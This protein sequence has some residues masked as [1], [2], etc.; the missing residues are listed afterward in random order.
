MRRE[1]SAEELLP[2]TGHSS[3][4]MVDYYNRK[5]LDMALEGLPK[6]GAAAAD[7]LFK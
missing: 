7:T 2:M 3:I 5:V 6:A 1:L 4:E